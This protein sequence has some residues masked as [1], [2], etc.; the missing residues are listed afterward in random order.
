MCSHVLTGV[1]AQQVVRAAAR[2]AVRSAERLMIPD[3]LHAYMRLNIFNGQHM[4]AGDVCFDTPDVW[5]MFMSQCSIWCKVVRCVCL[6]L[7]DRTLSY[8]W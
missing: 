1:H 2:Q 6:Q 7:V 3:A 4:D 5:N 8:S